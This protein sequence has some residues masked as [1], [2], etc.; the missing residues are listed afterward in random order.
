MKIIQTQNW[1]T[2]PDHPNLIRPVSQRKAKEVFKELEEALRDAELY[3]DEYFL[4]DRDFD[5]E[6]AEFP[7]VR[8]II[9]YAQWG[10]NEGIYLEVELVIFD[11]NSK[12]YRRKN[13]ATGKTL[14]EDSASFDRMQYIA[15]YTRQLNDANMRWAIEAYQRERE[16]ENKAIRELLQELYPNREI[17]DSDVDSARYA[18]EQPVKMDENAATEEQSGGLNKYKENKNR[19]FG[20]DITKYRL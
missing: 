1:E 4:L 13:F 18:I 6:K 8:D 12:T 17:N 10:G 20:I 19:T 3:P 9:C 11:E 2:V 16:N 5:D 14:A 15:G 7:I